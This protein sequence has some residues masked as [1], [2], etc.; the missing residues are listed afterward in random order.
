MKLKTR[1]LGLK[2]YSRY[3]NS[4]KENVENYAH[5]R[6]DNELQKQNLM[7]KR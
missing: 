6:D 1:S 2:V 7:F 3:E 5:N 4:F